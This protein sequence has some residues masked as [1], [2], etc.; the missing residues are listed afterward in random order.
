[1]ALSSSE[2]RLIIGEQAV[3]HADIKV[4]EIEIHGQVFGNVEVTAPG[5]DSFDWPSARRSS[6]LRSRYSGWSRSGRSELHAW[7][8]D[9]NEDR[10][11]QLASG[12]EPTRGQPA[13]D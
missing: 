11:E 5:G 13:N 10:S 1:M 6:S 12:P 7:L 3:V 9:M 4:G 2:D 8:L